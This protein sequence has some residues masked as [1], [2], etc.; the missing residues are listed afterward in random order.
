MFVTANCCPRRRCS[1]MTS[2]PESDTAFAEWSHGHRIPFWIPK[3]PLFCSWKHSSL[4]CVPAACPS[5]NQLPLTKGI[6]KAVTWAYLPRQGWNKA[7]WQKPYFVYAGLLG[8]SFVQASCQLFVGRFHG[9]GLD[10]GCTISKFFGWCSTQKPQGIPG[11]W[12]A[13]GPLELSRVYRVLALLPFNWDTNFYPPIL[14]TVGKTN[15]KPS[16]YTRMS[17]KF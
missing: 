16:T 11:P 7:S 15:H 10:W 17:S 14:A 8:C 1:A 12:L 9:F 3:S 2:D 4:L 5:L 6:A 13:L